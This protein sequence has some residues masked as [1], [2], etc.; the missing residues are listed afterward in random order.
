MVQIVTFLT[1]FVNTYSREFTKQ[2]AAT[3]KYAAKPLR[4]AL[5]RRLSRYAPKFC[6]AQLISLLAS[7]QVYNQSEWNIW[8]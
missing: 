2:R 3:L 5:K 1:I 7:H 8:D 6:L 4:V